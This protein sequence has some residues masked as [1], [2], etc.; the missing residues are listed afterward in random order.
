ML[1]QIN[2]LDDPLCR[3]IADDPV[4]PELPIDFRVND[5]SSIFVLLDDYQRPQ[6][7]VCCRFKDSVPKSVEELAFPNM[8]E[9]H[10]AVFYTIWSYRSGAGQELILTVRNWLNH[11]RQDITQYV[12][13]SPQTEMARRFHLR[14]GA[15]VF[16][17]NQETVN[18]RYL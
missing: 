2:S 4:R 15:E 18:Y 6:S 17:I 3:L 7:V 12:T 10:V 14:N 11:H 1:H 16:R 5:H 13:L 8:I 9:P